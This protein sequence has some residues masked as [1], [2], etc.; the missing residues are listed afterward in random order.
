[1]PRVRL[2]P[3]AGGGS[4]C[5]SQPASSAGDGNRRGRQPRP[6]ALGRRLLALLGSRDSLSDRSSWRSTLRSGS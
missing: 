6:E 1:M 4:R 3:A 2:D 5:G